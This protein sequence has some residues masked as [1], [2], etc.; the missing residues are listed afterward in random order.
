MKNMENNGINSFKDELEHNITRDNPSYPDEKTMSDMNMV[1]GMLSDV[2]DAQI[3]DS[4][5]LVEMVS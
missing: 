3:Y 2:S 5:D 4:V 1:E